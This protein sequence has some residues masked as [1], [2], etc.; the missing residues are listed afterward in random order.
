M[1]PHTPPR[2]HTN[3]AAGINCNIRLFCWRLHSRPS[4]QDAKKTL[5][6]SAL[7]RRGVAGFYARPFSVNPTFDGGAY[8]GSVSVVTH[9]EVLLTITVWLTVGCPGSLTRRAR[10]RVRRLDH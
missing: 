9:R 3:V 10:L 4:H 7:K 8:L 2:L 1:G 6:F 5:L